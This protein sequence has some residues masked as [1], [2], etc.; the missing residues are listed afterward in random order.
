MV[1]LEGVPQFPTDD[2]AA[3][4]GSRLQRLPAPRGAEM[5][6]LREH[7]PFVRYLIRDAGKTSLGLTFLSAIG[8]NRRSRSPTAF[9]V[10]SRRTSNEDSGLAG[11]STWGEFPGAGRPRLGCPLLRP[12][13]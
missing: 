4:A 12:A 1:S 7:D 2:A 9:P 3:N 5:T 10:A 11:A 6:N 8:S 13:Q